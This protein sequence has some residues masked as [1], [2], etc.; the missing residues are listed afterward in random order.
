VHDLGLMAAELIAVA[1][2]RLG[3]ADAEPAD[4]L[5]QFSRQSGS[6]WVQRQVPSA[7]RAPAVTV[8]GARC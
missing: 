4:L 5:W 8:G 7:E 1:S 2:R 3:V 6:P